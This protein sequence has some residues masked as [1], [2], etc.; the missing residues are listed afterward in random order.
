MVTGFG[1]ETGYVRECAKVH[2]GEIGLSPDTEATSRALGVSWTDIHQAICGGRVVWSDK[3]DASDTKSIMV[4][5][6]CDGD[7]LRLTIV[8]RSSDYRLLVTSVERL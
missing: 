3:E 2:S 4:G 7:R 8:W 5:R 6:N 1:L